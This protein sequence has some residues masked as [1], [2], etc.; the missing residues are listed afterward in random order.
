MVLPGWVSESND[1][2][3]PRRPDRGAERGLFLPFQ[4]CLLSL[5]T[6]L[7]IYARDVLGDENDM[8]LTTVLGAEATVV[9]QGG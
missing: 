7:A 5:Q 2:L 9:A 1:P 4:T 6:L 8:I 3:I